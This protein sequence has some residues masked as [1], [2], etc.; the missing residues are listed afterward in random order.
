MVIAIH[1]NSLEQRSWQLVSTN[2]FQ[3][4]WAKGT[5]VERLACDLTGRLSGFRIPTVDEALELVARNYKSDRPVGIYIEVKQPMFHDSV[6]LSL[7]PRLAAAIATSGMASH[8]ADDV[9]LQ[10]FEPLV[11]PQKLQENWRFLA[12]ERHPIQNMEPLTMKAHVGFRA[13]R[14]CTSP[15]PDADQ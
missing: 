1:S 12:S 11:S 3:Q 9:I 14:T 4:G 15:R 6:G 8:A 2:P 10:S 13:V 5:L 7:E